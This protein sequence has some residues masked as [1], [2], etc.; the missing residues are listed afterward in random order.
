[1]VWCVNIFQDLTLDSRPY[2]LYTLGLIYQHEEKLADA[3][4]N[5]QEGIT[6][7]QQN[8]DRF[9]EAYLQRAIGKMFL[10]LQAHNKSQ[11]T[12]EKAV[13]LF[14]QIGLETEVIETS[15]HLAWDSGRSPQRTT[16]GK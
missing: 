9:I 13:Q 15:R 8:G 10:H 16:T 2:A 12:L 14:E 4:V 1:M 3:E 5:F 7:A 11:A 6:I